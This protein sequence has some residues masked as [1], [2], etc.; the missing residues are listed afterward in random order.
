[1]TTKTEKELYFRFEQAARELIYPDLRSGYA[2]HEKMLSTLTNALIKVHKMALED[3]DNLVQ[4]SERS[5]FDTEQKFNTL[6]IPS[7]AY[8]APFAVCS[9]SDN[10]GS[11]MQSFQHSEYMAKE[12]EKRL[13]DRGDRNVHIEYFDISTGQYVK[14]KPAHFKH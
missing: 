2:K 6:S 14:E 5:I 8:G 1:M 10:Y 7:Y 11:G 3:E 13:I 9:A 12:I 4:V